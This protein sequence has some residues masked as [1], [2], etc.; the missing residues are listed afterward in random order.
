M[1]LPLL[2]LVVSA[3]MVIV[4]TSVLATSDSPFNTRGIT[5]WGMFIIGCIVLI[6][7]L[8]IT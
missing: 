3:V 8:L 7:L 6:D 5:G 2:A 1:V 4:G